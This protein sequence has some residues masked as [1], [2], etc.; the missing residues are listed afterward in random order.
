MKENLNWT[1]WTTFIIALIGA[2]SWTPQI[3]LWLQKND[4]YGKVLSEYETFAKVPNKSELQTVYLQK[5]S[6]FSKN[7]DFFPK[8]I[9]VFIKYPS[10]KD[11][12]SCTLWTWRDLTFTFNENGKSI[13]KR[14]NIS[15]KD[16][17]IQ[18]VIYPKN[19]TI[20]GYIS[21]SVDYQKDAMFNYLRYE[22]IDFKG[23]KRELKIY[24]KEIESNKLAHEDNIWID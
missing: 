11:E 12:L 2:L 22:F 16:Y 13:Q 15:L 20:V 14:L 24:D 19:E 6:L 3:Y 4:I 5:I 7:K 21:F 17:L 1:F 18:K 23:K 8:D 10:N 9:K